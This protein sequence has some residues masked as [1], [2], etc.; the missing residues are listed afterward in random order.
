MNGNHPTNDSSINILNLGKSK[1]K[2]LDICENTV[3]KRY[4]KILLRFVIDKAKEMEFKISLQTYLLIG[5]LPLYKSLGF[6]CLKMMIYCLVKK[7]VKLTTQIRSKLT[8]HIRSKLTT[9]IR[10]KLT[11]WILGDFFS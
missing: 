1:I 2:I 7:T 8:T 6:T 5:L 10:S 9:W 3:N 11:T 4:A